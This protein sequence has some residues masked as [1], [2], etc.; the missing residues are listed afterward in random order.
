MD[1][2]PG[3]GPSGAGG[4]TEL[5]L[6]TLGAQSKTDAEG[7]VQT[8]GRE[9]PNRQGARAVGDAVFQGLQ[10]PAG[11]Y[12]A[13]AGDRFLDARWSKGARL[14]PGDDLRGFFGW[15]EPRLRQR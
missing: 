8:R 14:L 6:C 1:Q 15:R 11:R 4:E 2:G 3:V 10:E 12:R 13:G 9:T 7:G 5:R